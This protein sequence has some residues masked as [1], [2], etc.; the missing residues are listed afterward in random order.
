MATCDD[1]FHVDGV[2]CRALPN[3]K[4]FIGYGLPKSFRFMVAMRIGE[5]REDAVRRHKKFP[6]ARAA[7]QG[8]LPTVAHLMLS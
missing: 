6:A 2:R 8:E 1:D 4:V 7:A 3:Y 5:D